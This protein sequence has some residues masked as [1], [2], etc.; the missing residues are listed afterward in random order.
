M[1]AAR[2]AAGRAWD[3]VGYLLYAGLVCAGGCA[4][5]F[6]LFFPMATDGCH[7]A[8]CEAGYR[9][10]PAMITMWIG[11]GLALLLTLVVMVVQS[12]RGKPVIG[13]P[14]AGLAAV[15]VTF[16]VATHLVLG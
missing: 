1:N 5:W 12:Y 8:A 16:L 3:I 11:V 9:V 10:W 7:D 14:F 6:S 2:R 15:G 13:W 4:I